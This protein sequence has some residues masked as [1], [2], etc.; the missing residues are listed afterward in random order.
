MDPLLYSIKDARA[1]IG[2]ISQASIYNLINSGQ[3]RTRRIGRRRF[4]LRSSLL[5]LLKTD[6]ELP[7]R[8]KKVEGD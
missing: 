3:I 4:I 6:R 2:N 5:E 1:M 7:R 8:R